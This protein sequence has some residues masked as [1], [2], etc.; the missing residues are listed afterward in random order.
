MKYKSKRKIKSRRHDKGMENLQRTIMQTRFLLMR[1]D[2]QIAI[3]KFE[4]GRLTRAPKKY[5]YSVSNR[6]KFQ[7][8]MSQK[9]SSPNLLSQEDGKRYK[10]SRC[11]KGYKSEGA[12]RNHEKKCIQGDIADLGDSKFEPVA[13]S[14]AENFTDSM[15]EEKVNDKKRKRSAEKEEFEGGDESLDENIEE[16]KKAKEARKE[17]INKMN[18]ENDLNMGYDVDDTMIGPAPSTQCLGWRAAAATPAHSAGR[19]SRSTW[20]FFSQSFAVSLRR[21]TS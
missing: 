18:V 17:M 21:A 8:K 13:T 6:M 11:E 10:C 20:H 2:L 9:N 3:C 19:P 4:K 14:T 15:V 16:A 5:N 7:R 12:W 1:I